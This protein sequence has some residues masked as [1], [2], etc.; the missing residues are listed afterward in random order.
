MKLKHRIMLWY[1]KRKAKKQTVKSGRQVAGAPRTA[2]TATATAA[3]SGSG[4]A[5]RAGTAAKSGSAEA[6][7]NATSAA[8]DRRASR[9]RRSS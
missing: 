4:W 3:R 6:A 9:S 2:G 5:R 7:R 1:A 8:S